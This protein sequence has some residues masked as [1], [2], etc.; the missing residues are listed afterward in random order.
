[1]TATPN[2]DERRQPEGWHV[3]QTIPARFAREMLAGAGLDRATLLPILERC[4]LSE[5]ALSGH[6]R[7]VPRDYLTLTRLVI[8]QSG[9]EMRGCFAKPVPLGTFAQLLRLLVYLPTLEAVFAEA[10][11]FYALY[12]ETPPWQVEKHD[13]LIRLRLLPARAE[14]VQSALYPHFMLL[15]LW[16][17]GSWLV[18]ET[19]PVQRVVLPESLAEF[20]KQA[21]FLFGRQA[22]FGP[23]AYLELAESELQRAPLRAPH[24]AARLARYMPL[25]L[26][27]PGQAVDLESQVRGLLSAARPFASLSEQQAARQLGMARQT[28]VRRLAL[29]DTSYHRIREELR[30]DLACA[31]LSQGTQSIALIAEH[32]GYS[33]PSAFQRAFKQWTGVPPGE[34][35]RERLQRQA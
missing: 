21:R 12:N 16:H 34:Y 14:Q 7:L 2:S 32:M 29:L 33:E 25:R 22:E 15:S 1:M 23:H 19:L 20:S 5:A 13:K 26:V 28:L 4:D 3:R 31:L 8:A 30:R 10:A 27:S 35:R 9:D 17:V 24:E 11:R 18:K 6:S